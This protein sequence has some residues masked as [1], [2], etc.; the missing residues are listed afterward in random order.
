MLSALALLLIGGSCAGPVEAGASSAW[1]DMS[2]WAAELEGGG[3]VEAVEGELVIDVPLGATVWYRPMLKAPVVISY[4]AMAVDEGGPNDRVSDLNCFW[5]ARDSRTPDDL[6]AS[7]RSGKFSDYDI[8]RTYYV[9]VGGNNN[10]TTRF[11]R[12]TGEPGNRPLLPEHDR[13]DPHVLLKPNVWQDIRI[14]VL[15]EGRTRFHLNGELLFEVDD[16]APYTSGWF[17]FRTVN[18]HLRIADFQISKPDNN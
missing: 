10:T 4:R 6:F 18:N 16:P 15:A 7:S 13:A 12:Y 11:R 9:G 2:R 14:E 17:G 5:M 8:L 1:N 3:R